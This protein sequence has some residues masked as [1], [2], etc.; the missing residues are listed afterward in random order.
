LIVPDDLVRLIDSL[1]SPAAGDPAMATLARPRRDVAA[2][3]RPDVVKAVVDAKGRALYFS[4]AP[5]PSGLEAGGEA[6]VW[7]QHI[8]VYAFRREF[9]QEFT[10]LSAGALERL[11]RLEQLRALENGHA[12]RVL[13][14]EHEYRGID[15]EE[16]YREFVAA[17]RE[18]RP[19]PQ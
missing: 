5:I 14:T 12:I 19:R 17:C 7:L 6:A 2:Q 13:L 4:R 9:L 8:G 15:T 10:R 11:E 18:G 3:R 1:R 16:E